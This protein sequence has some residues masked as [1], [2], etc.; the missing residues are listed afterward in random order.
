MFQMS[1]VGGGFTAV[2]FT[3]STCCVHYVPDVHQMQ[4][5]SIVYQELL[6]TSIPSDTCLPYPL[7]LMDSVCVCLCG[8]C[9]RMGMVVCVCF[10]KKKRKNVTL[11]Y[12]FREIWA[13][14]PG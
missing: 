1:P 9:E 7:V 12:H 8:V 6:H 10:K 5:A 2:L 11:Y 14:F 3:S 4:D 13:A